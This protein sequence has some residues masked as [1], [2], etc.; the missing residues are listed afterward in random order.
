[1]CFKWSVAR[2]FC[3]DEKKTTQRI[4][5]KQREEAQKLNFVSIEFPMAVNKIYIY[6]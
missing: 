3:T 1:M 2:H 5:K 6:I 4:V